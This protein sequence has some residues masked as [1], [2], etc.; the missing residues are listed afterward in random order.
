MRRSDA[1]RLG[2][3]R[4][5]PARWIG[6][7]ESKKRV[8]QQLTR[9]DIVFFFKKVMTNDPHGRAEFWLRYVRANTPVSRPL[10]TDS[11]RHRLHSVL[12][13][14]QTLWKEGWFAK[15]IHSRLW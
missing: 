13:D 6:M 3:P 14:G 11:D 1:Q 4:L 8:L 2:D 12:R 9:D 7:E 5:R 10:L 15:R